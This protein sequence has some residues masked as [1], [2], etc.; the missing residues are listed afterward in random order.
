MNF[1][2]IYSNRNALKNN[3]T[4]EPSII[5]ALEIKKADISIQTC[6]ALSKQND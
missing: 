3:G 5:L 4:D 1:R 2:K 6:I